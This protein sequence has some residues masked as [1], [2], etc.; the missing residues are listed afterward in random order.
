MDPASG[1]REPRLAAAIRD[2]LARRPLRLPPECLYDELG[3][4]LFE[5]ITHLPEYGLTRAGQRLLLRHSQ[6]MASRLP[7][8]LDVVELGSGSGRKTRPLLEQL[9]RRAKLRYVPVD[10]SAAALLDCGNEIGGIEGVEL[11]PL[12]ARHLDGL[13]RAAAA[14]R[15]GV[16]LLVLFLG[17]NI[18]NF[19]RDE[20]RVFLREIRASLAAGDALLIG[21][22][23]EKPEPQLL[24][25]YDDPI[26]LTAAFNLNVLGRLNRELSADFD[27]RGFSHRARYDR[28]ERRI[29]MHLVSRRAQRACVGELGMALE[30]SPGETIWTES[31]HK[32]GAGEIAGL[33]E[34][35]G[36]EALADWTDADWPFSQTLLLAR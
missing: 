7:S 29:E 23:L 14:R 15:E 26:G 33:G 19:D 4:A 2:G 12:E 28:A 1:L 27:V 17:S 20:A 34:G 5:A 35:A 9:A 13:K 11:L 6:A 30:L 3:S 32:F 18:G 22:D 21:A 36:F 24:S 31:S 10:I 25:A 16:S 8:L